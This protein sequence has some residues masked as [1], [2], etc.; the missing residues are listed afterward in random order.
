MTRP[1]RKL[2]VGAPERQVHVRLVEGSEPTLVLLH[3]TASSS[4]C[5]EPL[6]RALTLPNRLIAIDLPGFGG[7]DEIEGWPALAAYRDCI[8]ATLDQL[9]A[10]PIVVLGHHT[11]A[12]LAIELAV[13]CQDRVEAIILVG[14]VLMSQQ[15]R[16]D[17]LVSHG[18]PLT[19]DREG[20]H[21]LVNW[22][23]AA[24]YNYDC[25][26]ELLH[27][28]VVAMLR[29]WRGRAQAYRAVAGQDT[30]AL[31]QRVVARVLLIT[32]PDD[33]FHATLDRAIAAFPAAEV[34]S[35]GGGNFQPT[36]DPVGIAGAVESFLARRG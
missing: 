36:L 32:S 6:M 23:Y 26:T 30:A 9:G 28:E 8:V 16:D 27:Q 35:V 25:P 20:S 19:P 1:I 14:P 21:L 11:G 29:A 13:A 22:Q 33:Y 10:G 4:Q 2:Y 3:Q 15:E 24:G 31:A 18:E 34:A 5:F 17:F 12:S 7:S